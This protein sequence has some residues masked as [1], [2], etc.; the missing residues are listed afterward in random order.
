MSLRSAILLFLVQ[1]ILFQL[2]GIEEFRVIRIHPGGQGGALDRAEEIAGLFDWY[3]PDLLA[4]VGT[5]HG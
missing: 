4:A 5:I 2:V 1:E 3:T